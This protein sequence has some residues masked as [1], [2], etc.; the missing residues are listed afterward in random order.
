M[1]L[2]VKVIILLWS[3]NVTPV[4]LAVIFEE[5]WNT[6]LD[7]DALF[8]DGKPFFGNHKTIRGFLGGILAGSFI[9][10]IL[11]IP[12]WAA[13]SASTLSMVGDLLSSFIKRRLKSSEGT[14]YPIMDQV[15]EG[16]FPLFVLVPTLSLSFA[17]SFSV[18]LL[19]ILTAWP[20]AQFP[21]RILKTIPFIGYTR[22]LR[23]KIR[24]REWRGCDT[25]E[26]PFHPIINFERTF[27]YHWFM[28][29]V[30]KIL[31]LYEKGKQNALDV[32]L[33]KVIFEFDDLPQ[34]FDNYTI[35]FISDLHLD[36]LNG[37][38]ERV[39]D[40]VD[41]LNP[42]LCIMGGDYRTESWGSYSTALTNIK[43]V[44]DHT[45]AKQGIYAVLGNHDCLEMISP[46][47]EKGV[48][49]LVNDC[50]SIEKNG[51][52]I[53]LAGVDDPYYFEGHDLEETFKPIPDNGFTLF[54]SHTPGIYREAVDFDPQLYLCGHTH[55]GQVRLPYFGAV[56]THCK[57]PKELVY[58]KWQ[59]KRMLGYTSS[60][61]G[62]SGIPVR[63]G[64][65]GEIVLIT[66]KKRSVKL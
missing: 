14:D 66:L 59:H 42:D 6:P 34:G 45:K 24:F 49:F 43:T 35:L 23:S 31:G 22:R 1:L 51:D 63:F 27:Y 19:F 11:G 46:L 2:F 4:L 60:G 25:I 65:R 56:V 5:K 8:I 13:L 28:K 29:S 64:C 32:Q 40:I 17:Q 30:F 21:T 53:W 48:T 3:V 58:G 20:A 33:N 12:F 55:A 62:T 39:K 18:I 54:I 7:R 50:A 61:V 38:V 52:Q 9:G 44:L 37:L 57:V 15:F 41:P 16:G 36:C 26:Y 10:L 47:K